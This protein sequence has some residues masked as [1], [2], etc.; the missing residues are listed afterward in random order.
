MKLSDLRERDEQLDEILP[1]LAMG[2][3]RLAAPALAKGKGRT[4]T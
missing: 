1:A 2:A 4:V 3:A